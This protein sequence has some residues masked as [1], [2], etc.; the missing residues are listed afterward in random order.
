MPL[1]LDKTRCWFGFGGDGVVHVYHREHRLC[2]SA[3][4]TP[5]AWSVATRVELRVCPKCLE[6]VQ[7]AKHEKRA[8]HYGS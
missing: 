5:T 3:E 6:L 8:A 7:R 1:E 4:R 2:D